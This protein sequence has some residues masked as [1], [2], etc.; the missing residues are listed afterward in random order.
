MPFFILKT[1]VA[2]VVSSLV[3]GVVVA[4][5]AADDG[6]DAGG[7]RGRGRRRRRRH[8]QV[9]GRPRVLVE[10]GGGRVKGRV[11]RGLQEQPLPV[12]LLQLL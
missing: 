5:A 4:A 6:D 1:G 11:P 7:P 10:D 2:H 9:H 8:R 12:V 3:Y